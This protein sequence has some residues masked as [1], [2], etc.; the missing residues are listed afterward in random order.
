VSA[1]RIAVISDVH[2][3]IHAFEKVVA[4]LVSRE[5]DSVVFLG[6]LVFLGLYPQECFDLLSELDPSVAIKGNTDANIEELAGFEPSNEFE[7]QLREMIVYADVRMTPRTKQTIR[8]WNIAERETIRGCATI[9]CHGSPYSFKDLLTEANRDQFAARIEDERVSAIY[10]AHTHQSADFMIGGT[11]V[12]NFGAVGYSFDR[13]TTARYGI[14][15]FSEGVRPTHEILEVAYDI[16]KY[17][18]EIRRQ[19][20]AFMENLLY[21]LEHGLP[22][23]RKN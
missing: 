14:V 6:D 19:K 10:C 2:G 20:P 22:E 18:D 9:F 4:D 5:V 8:S 15:E 7:R 13:N 12:T 1:V 16:E 23:P 17:K 3:N 11:S 21:A